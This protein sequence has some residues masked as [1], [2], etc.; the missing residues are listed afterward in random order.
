[1]HFFAILFSRQPMGFQLR[2]VRVQKWLQL[3]RERPTWADEFNPLVDWWDSHREAWVE[4]C[5]SRTS[6]TFLE[7]LGCWSWCAEGFAV[8]SVEMPGFADCQT[9]PLLRHLPPAFAALPWQEDASTWDWCGKR[10][11]FANVEGSIVGLLCFAAASYVAKPHEQTKNFYVCCN[12]NNF[13]FSSTEASESTI[14]VYKLSLP[15]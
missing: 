11:F 9:C 15:Y 5:W 14:I 12:G 4:V 2:K 3:S 6:R 1:M 7:F 8:A 13:L 10:R